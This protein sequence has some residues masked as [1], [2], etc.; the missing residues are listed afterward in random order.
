MMMIYPLFHATKELALTTQN[1]DIHMVYKND[2]QI[3]FTGKILF[4]KGT[5]PINEIIRF[6]MSANFML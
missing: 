1:I 6:L 3:D 4:K 5:Y 2:K